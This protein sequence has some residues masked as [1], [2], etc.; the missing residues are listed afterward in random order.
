MF[1]NFDSEV[2]N[3]HGRW[4]S[5]PN[6]MKSHWTRPYV[7]FYC[8]K[9]FSFKFC[10]SPG[11]YIVWINGEVAETEN[12]AYK[13]SENS[14]IRLIADET[15]NTI[16]FKGVETEGKVE[17]AKSRDKNLLI[18]GDSLTHSA[19]SHSVL[20]PKW[21]DCDYTCI[22]QGGMALCVDRGY[23]NTKEE[24]KAYKG[25]SGAFFCLTS[26]CE[27]IVPMIPFD[28]ESDRK[29]DA[30]ILNIGTNDHLTDETYVE[31]F[32][33]VYRE[34]MKKLNALYPDIPIYLALPV[35]DTKDSDIGWRRNTIEMCAKEAESTYPN[36][37]YISSRDWKVEISEDGVH[38]TT[39]G[40]RVYA[41]ELKKAIEK[42]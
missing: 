6:G 13:V 34:F 17:F 24:L 5:T 26:P 39:E 16:T 40:Y 38:P 22:A 27:G 33:T 20:L 10:E 3:Y 11:K 7:E 31:G 12:G 9:D 14:L 29:Y 42:I 18:I 41:E 23:I 30:V 37:K 35:A 19:V 1:Y 25:M 2:F 15:A 4:E 21:W 36:M 28:F 8:D 32:A